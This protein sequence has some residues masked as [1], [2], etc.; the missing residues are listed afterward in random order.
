MKGR[1]LKGIALTVAAAVALFTT[2]F[3]VF[4]EYVS[5]TEG[6][7][8]I[9]ILHVN[10]VHCGINADD[11]TFGYAD[12]A[13]Y[14]AKL[15]AEGY[16]TLLVDAGDFVQGDV[17]GTLSGGEYLIDIMNELGFDVA[18]LG[19]HEFDY[20]M[21]QFGKLTEKADFKIVSS[22]FI[23][24]ETDKPVF[25]GWSIIE[26]DGVKLGFVGITTPE[27]VV[28]SDPTNFKNEDGEFIYSFCAGDNGEELYR[29]VQA[30][31]DAVEA[32]GADIIVAVGHLGIDEQS[33]PWT[34]REVIENT[35]GID[36]FIDGHSHSIIESETVKDESGSEVVLTSTGTKLQSI[37]EVT[38][39]DGKITSE[40]IK[41]G[42][43]TVSEDTSSDESKAY[44]AA[45]EFIGRIEEQ[46]EKL[47]NT[48]V[49]KTDVDLTTVDPENPEERI[50][51]NKKTNLGD[52]CAD[53]YRVMMGADIAFVNG[54]GIRENI[55]SG[56]ITYGEIIA[57]HPYGNSICL[58]EATGQEILDALEL[59]SCS[60]PGESGGFLQVSGI[61]YEIH[62]Y[63][64]SSVVLT[65]NK[66][67]VKV[68]GEYRVKNVLVNGEP[69]E[70]DKTYTLASHNYMLKSGGDGFTMFK[71]NT[72]L[73]DEV[74][75]D[76]Q[77]L[78]NY[79]IDE[80]GGIVGEDYA[81]PLGDGRIKVVNEAPSTDA[82]VTDDPTVDNPVTGVVGI[83]LTIIAAAAVAVMALSRHGKYN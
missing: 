75:I 14:E 13:A 5:N 83:D 50:I 68:D 3:T 26:A 2:Q 69:L 73:K 33:S 22:N 67:F 12:I 57:V 30:S 32:A 53:A 15:K 35:S 28:K 39:A 78:I 41:K 52:F 18:T 47:V 44:N 81:D 60:Y 58:V 8:G 66:E 21:E 36:L 38:I 82:P 19:N 10:D 4:A 61:S 79:I 31:V 51:R 43:Y 27:T 37:G 49:A 76:N 55:Y 25:D 48:V 20:G 34:S 11:D 62:S 9:V 29:S 63:I 7:K 6:G 77:V 80:L 24:L 70:L 40:L 23:D 45:S 65:D 56:D 74:L 64:P 46:Y 72:I 16:T 1:F 42:D 54:G 71:N 17:I 59:G